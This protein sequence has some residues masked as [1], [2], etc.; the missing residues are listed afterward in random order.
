M[1]KYKDINDTILINNFYKVLAENYGFDVIFESIGINPKLNINT[2][3][4][5]K[6]KDWL[7]I[8]IKDDNPKIE[9]LRQLEIFREIGNEPR[10]LNSQ[11]NSIEKLYG[12]ILANFKDNYLIEYDLKFLDYKENL[13]HLKKSQ[14]YSFRSFQLK[15]F[16][17]DNLIHPL[18]VFLLGCYIIYSDKKFWINRIWNSMWGDLHDIRK[19]YS[20]RTFIASVEYNVSLL[21]L[22]LDKFIFKSVFFMWMLSSLFHDIG[23]SIEDASEATRILTDTYRNLP[24][25]R[26]G[27]LKSFKGTKKNIKL[28]P[29]CL[30]FEPDEIGEKKWKAL[31]TFLKVLPTDKNKFIKKR[32][33][34]DYKKLDHG[35]ISAVL[36]ADYNFLDEYNKYLIST[37]LIY[38][39]PLRYFF[40]SLV[41]YSFISMSL[42]NNPRYFFV[43]P[44]T[45]L[46][47]ATDTLQEWERITIIGDTERKI[48]PCYKIR[49]KFDNFKIN[50]YKG[51]IIEAIIP[52]KEPRNRELKEI[53]KRR[54]P[55]YEELCTKLTQYRDDTE[56]FSKFFNK[57]VEL[58]IGYL[59]A[60]EIIKMKI[61]G[62]CGQVICR[63]D[64]SKTK[65]MNDLFCNNPE[66]E[67]YGRM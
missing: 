46:L 2:F 28:C 64:N 31:I 9:L 18:R 20:N 30:I 65:N 3:E 67:A 14:D 15:D 16:K 4:L 41:H 52:F 26:W 32:I 55:R 11:I 60:N 49:L 29:M 40:Y 45:Q 21:G 19:G 25:F 23:R 7:E 62:L 10:K 58:R 37:N 12:S 42:H 66:C 24:Y 51:K 5:K 53:F 13:N 48:Y 57:G 43:S 6:I 54:K 1:T 50:D 33:E 47:I 8:N 27:Y 22:S 61:C 39:H 59:E 34:I 38:R 44:L 63:T 17:R 36:S 56:Y 35:V